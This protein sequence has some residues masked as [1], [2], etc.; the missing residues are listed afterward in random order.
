MSFFTRDENQTGKMV[1]KI[2]AGKK[3]TSSTPQNSRPQSSSRA[4]I[5]KLMFA[6]VARPRQQISEKRVFR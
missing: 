2:S 5:V 6:C 1:R 3:S 4:S